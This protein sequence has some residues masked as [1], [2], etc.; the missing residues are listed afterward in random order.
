MKIKLAKKFTKILFLFLTAGAACS[1]Q[2]RAEKFYNQAMGKIEQRKFLDAVD[3]LE[4]SAKLE[5]SNRLWSKTTFE[6]AR[7]LR[8]EIQDYNKALQVYKELILKSE[9]ATIRLQSQQASAEIYFENLQDYSSA[10]KEYLLLE[11]LIHEPDKLEQIRLKIAQSYRYT[12]NLKTALEYIDVFMKE[13][14]ETKKAM[15]K[16]KA[17]IFLSQKKYDDALKCYGQI[18]AEDKEY[19]ANENLYVAEDEALEEKQD[20]KG[21]M[22]YLTQN[23]DKIKDKTY[24]ELRFKRLNEKLENKPFIRGVRK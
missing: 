9:D 3:L 12:G 7:I 1:C 14:K 19:F 24:L 20:Y 22:A 5:K 8:F 21:A 10:T 15:L 18:F 17:Q 11:S 23:K 2:S 4:D 16:L 13:A 6:S